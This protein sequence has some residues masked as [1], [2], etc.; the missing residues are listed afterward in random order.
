MRAN[1]PGNTVTREARVVLWRT[2]DGLAFVAGLSL[3]GDAVVTWEP[4][5]GRQPPATVDEWH[6]CDV[7]MRAHRGTHFARRSGHHV[8]DSG[9]Q[10]R[11]QR[12]LG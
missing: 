12:D 2:G 7:A 1:Q 8:E 10:P 3:T 5:A 6:D 11:F 9:R 4:Q